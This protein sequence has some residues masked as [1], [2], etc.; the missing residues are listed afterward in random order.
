MLE[1]LYRAQLPVVG[2]PRPQ[3]AQLTGLGPFSWVIPH[4][5]KKVVNSRSRSFFSP[6]R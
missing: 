3:F 1:L 4:R 6:G 5:Q 2:T